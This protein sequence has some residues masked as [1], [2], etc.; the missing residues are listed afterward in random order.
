MSLYRDVVARLRPDAINYVF[1]DEAQEIDGFE[2]AVDGLHLRADVD[3]YVTG[4]NARL[5][6]GELATLLSGRYVEIPLLPLSFREYVTARR[7]DLG[8]DAILRRALARQ[9]FVDYARFGAF[10]YATA[11]QPDLDLVR[12]HLLGILNTVL[13][14]DVVARRK[15]ARA[16]TLRDVVA[17]MLDN[18][19]NLTTPKRIADTLVST[20]RRVAPETVTGYLTALAESFVLY[21]ARRYDI[22]GRR[23]LENTA[24]YYAVDPGLRTALL[25]DRRRDTGHVLENI[26][27]LELRRRFREVCV[28][29]LGTAAVDFIAESPD[30]PTYVQVA[31]SVA[32]PSVLE[33]ELAPLRAIPDHYPRLLLTGD[34]G[35]FDQNGVRQRNVVGWLLAA[36]P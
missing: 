13:L 23:L 28:G 22:R 10:P 7:P 15:I 31:R 12:D 30:G 29:K 6:S 17:F 32:E 24:K 33:R 1:V 21:E 25:G 16:D 19:G 36:T 14:K 9:L 2:R 5:L 4:S 26:V 27:Y 20:G 11:L 35:S 8:D 18:V 3:L 34:E